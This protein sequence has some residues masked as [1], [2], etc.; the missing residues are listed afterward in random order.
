[1][2]KKVQAAEIVI[3]TT[4]GGSFKIFG[5]Q[6]DKATK[7]TE[8]MGRAAQTTDRAVKGVT[9]QS[10]NSTKE[11]SKMATMQGGLVAVYATL[12]AQVFAVSAAFQF[13]KSSMETRNLMAAQEAFGAV[14]GTAYRTLTKDIQAATNGMLD[15]KTA[16]SGAAIGIA[17]GLNAS[18]LKELGK[19]ATDASLALGRDLTDSFNRLI[20]G[21]TKAEPE[22]LDEL[23][24]VLRLENATTKYAVS[25]GKA[26]T[27]LNAYER[28]QAVLN[29][30][31]DQAETKFAAVQELMDP[32]AFALGQFQKE[33]DDLLMGFQKTVIEV[34][35]PAFKF[36]KDNSIAFLAA[37]G[38]FIAPIIRSLLPDLAASAQTNSQAATDAFN[39][40]KTAAADAKAEIGSVRDNFGRA[41][42]SQADSKSA[43][44]GMGV[45]KFS[46]EGGQTL[47]K[48]QIA[49]YRRALREKNGIYKKM[50]AAQR[51][52]F[53]FHLAAQEAM[54]QKGT[55]KQVQIVKTGESLKQAAI[56]GTVAVY[57]AGIAT[58]TRVTAMGA[59]AM[60]MAFAAAG[61]IGIV[62]MLYSLGEQLYRFF[63]PVS[64]E[65]KRMKEETEATTE[66]VGDLATE[67]ARMNEVREKGLLNL[68][69]QV[70]QT[71]NALASTDIAEHLR[72]FNKEVEK[73]TLTDD[74]KDS[75]VETA[76]AIEGLAP[77]MTGLSL[78]MEEGN[79][80][81]EE[82]I[83]K[84]TTLA[85]GY[86]NASTAAA[87]FQANQETLNKTL[88]KT[89]SKFKKMPY[90]DLKTAFSTSISGIE[91]ELGGSFYKGEGNNFGLLETQAANKI[92][93]Q[94]Q[95][96]ADAAA[97]LN[98]VEFGSKRRN[99]GN[100]R[101]SVNM[102]ASDGSMVDRDTMLERVKQ[103]TNLKSVQDSIMAQYDHAVKVEEELDAKAAKRVEQAKEEQEIIDTK[104]ALHRE[105]TA[106]QTH[107]EKLQTRGLKNVNDTLA[108]NKEL[109]RLKAQE[110]GLEGELN[111]IKQ[112]K[113]VLLNKEEKAAVEVQAAQLNQLST[114]EKIKTGL[115]AKED[116][117]GK[118]LYTQE[119]LN[120]L[121]EKDLIT[122]AEK[123][124]IDL[125]DYQIATD[126]VGVAKDN[127]DILT[128]T[129]DVL[130]ERLR[131]RELLAPFEGGKQA[132]A[133]AMADL[134]RQQKE[135][136]AEDKR[137]AKIGQVA[138]A[139]PG[140][141]FGASGQI[142][143]LRNNEIARIQAANAQRGTSMTNIQSRLGALNM[144]GPGTA[145]GL[146]E[147]PNLSEEQKAYN[148]IKQEELNLQHQIN[149]ETT[150]MNELID[151]KT[152]AQAMYLASV[153]QQEA[154][155]AREHVY[156]LNPASKLYHEA[157]L[158]AKKKGVELSEEQLEAL[159]QSSIETENLKIE[160]ELMTGIQD[161]LSQGFQNMFQ[162]MIDG[163]KSFGESM[164]DLTA[165]VL[166]DLAA[167]FV[168]A[169]ALKA[170]MAFFPGMGG[171]GGVMDFL[172]IGS[173][174]RYGGER[175]RGS[176]MVGG[177]ADGPESGYMAKLHGR[178]AIVPLG[179]DRSIPV[180]MRG[181]GGGMNT[182]NVSV[183]VSGNG[184]TAMSSNGGGALEGMGRQIGALVQQHLQQEMR[185]GGILNSQG[186]R[187]R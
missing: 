122:L 134:Q 182:V 43:L 141:Q 34:V 160:T 109:A 187:S 178:E 47:S 2:A 38:L 139:T 113:D 69:Q 120:E 1:M 86:L 154:A 4:D 157:V 163:S 3:K 156:S 170:M 56:K 65:A 137:L 175:T 107:V 165:Q 146:F 30:V 102:R 46:G 179:N 142:A 172:G 82:A 55:M 148:A 48:R 164:K 32:D 151:Q 124:E 174:D 138:G 14:T 96:E 67:L 128:Y 31:L 63:F 143:G 100:T 57:Q 73:G 106:L 8:K 93:R 140:V 186:N 26:R 97:R 115:L 150:K 108:T 133:N 21:V 11:F 90:Q 127:L 173:G 7:K 29:D 149:L 39:R 135:A 98:K 95:A 176:Y 103:A 12:A 185:P 152:G 162:A 101:A 77:E 130:R 37:I 23:G 147:G 167:M 126:A 28:T 180:E 87:Q 144:E 68:S 166:M 177:V 181:G 110:F 161:T 22:L 91:S 60:N 62:A 27:Q 105:Q 114:L 44:Q 64:E 45:K 99:M 171:S 52:E 17:S 83:S 153:A 33:F 118:A 70:T 184:Q 13:L 49:A 81:S 19:A 132:A 66:R 111:K 20:R 41:M 121:S 125:Q 10:S 85:S 88:D 9:K 123:A 42:P 36:F 155:L 58:M 131:I 5:Q 80:I 117:N 145:S 75:F 183:N 89:V 53:R 129:N 158:A 92:K 18:Q 168:R 61:I 94:E 78:A 79:E 74:L 40:M 25:V 84:Y 169:A 116:A 71:G 24:I 112:E 119:A 16:A 159:R 51:R 35:I 76:K 72:A 59:K 6:V 50:N 54:Q 15:F 136:A 104:T